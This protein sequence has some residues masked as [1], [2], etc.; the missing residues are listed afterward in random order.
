MEWTKEMRKEPGK[1]C[2]EDPLHLSGPKRR[3]G[4]LGRDAPK[5]A[6]W[7]VSRIP[8]LSEPE[9]RFSS[10]ATLLLGP[11]WM[12]QAVSSELTLGKNWDKTSP[13]WKASFVSVHSHWSQAIRTSSLV[14]CSTGTLLKFIILLQR[15]ALHF[16]FTLD[17]VYYVAYFASMS[18]RTEEKSQS[19]L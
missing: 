1:Q 6:I 15:K 19:S 14:Q 4:A 2:C 16:H 7:D 17:L 5:L 18:L 12:F 11:E 3:G 9:D 13:L 10:P 8:D